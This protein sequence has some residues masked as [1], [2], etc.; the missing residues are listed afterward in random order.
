PEEDIFS[1]DSDSRPSLVSFSTDSED[2]AILESAAEVLEI[3]ILDK[4]RFKLLVLKNL[5]ITA[6]NHHIALSAGKEYLF[7][8]LDDFSYLRANHKNLYKVE[9]GK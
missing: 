3:N 8:S 7:R 9:I 4:S 1:D 5:H 2:K 6:W